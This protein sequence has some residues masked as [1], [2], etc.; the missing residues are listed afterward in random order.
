MKKIRIP[1]MFALL[2]SA[3][4]LLLA[5]SLGIGSV[6]IPPGDI[7]RILTGAA[8]DARSAS[9]I[10]RIRLPRVLGA[11]VLGG[12]LGLSGF[13][14]H[15]FFRNPIA[16]PYVLG[17]SSGARLLVCITLL[18]L[19]RFF[20][21]APFICLMVAAF[22]GSLLVTG[23]VLLFAR[24]VRSMSTLLVVGIMVGNICTSVTDFLVT[25]ADEADV[26]NLHSWNMGSFSAITFE[27]LRPVLF[28]ILPASIGAFLLSK[29]ISACLLGE[30]YARSMGVNVR[31]FRL[32]LITLSSLLSASVTAIAGPVSFV[33]VAVPHMAR[34][35]FGTSRPIIIIPASFLSGSVFCLLCDLIAR[36]A[37]APSELAISSVTALFGAPV[38]IGLMIRRQRRREND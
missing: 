17:I 18:F 23:L 24:R 32:L 38:V 33:G 7:F 25:F 8:G 12:A 16:G 6:S 29:P 27:N 19:L 1:L 5:L 34:L 9:I 11:A 10:L 2:I 13:L 36:T 14:L 35:L 4:L 20:S 37:F 26:I 31:A 21:A 30:N 15:T 28:I 22:A 3:L